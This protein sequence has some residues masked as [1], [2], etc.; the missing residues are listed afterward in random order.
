[1]TLFPNYVMF[2]VMKLRTSIDESGRH[3]WTHNKTLCNLCSLFLESSLAVWLPWGCAS[4]KQHDWPG[5]T[6]AVFWN[7]TAHLCQS[8]ASHKQL[9][10]SDWA[11]Q[12]CQGKSVSRR[13][14]IHLMGIFGS[15]T[16]QQPYQTLWSTSTQ[17]SFLPSLLY[18]GSDLNHNLRAL[19]GSHQLPP[20]FLLQL[21]QSTQNSPALCWR[22]CCS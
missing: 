9:W 7:L 16:L 13:W 8:H 1:M 3:D 10:V 2:C 12:G 15:W 14:K 5:V 20:H 19:P 4:H 17:P 18:L 6:V 22:L 21:G 11:W